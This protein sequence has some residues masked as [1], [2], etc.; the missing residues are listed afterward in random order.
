MSWFDDDRPRQCRLDRRAFLHTDGFQYICHGC[1]YA[2]DPR[3][4]IGE[5]GDSGI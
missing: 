3:F 2:C 4:K 1:P 5:I